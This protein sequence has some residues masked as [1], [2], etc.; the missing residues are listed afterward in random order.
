METEYMRK[1]AFV[2]GSSKGIGKG[3]A[4]EFAKAG[5]DIALNHRDSEKE[6]REAAQSVESLGARAVV[7]QGDVS[8]PA[9]INRM[10]DAFS[11]AYD[12]LDVMVNNAGITRFQ[13]F[14]EADADVLD[15]VVNTNFRGSFL[16]AQRAARIMVEKEIP[17]LIVNITSN[18]QK[19]CWPIASV[20][21]AS[22]AAVNKFTENIAMELAPYGIRAV[23]IAPGY[24][25]TRERPPEIPRERWDGYMQTIQR[26]PLGRMCET[27]EVGRACVFLA[28]EGAQYITGACLYMDG[29]A[30]LPVV[31][32][33][34]YI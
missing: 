10:F 20:Y 19:G 16:C 9:D 6:A 25:K 29:G 13:P 22:K 5:Y 28:G 18:H 31:T 11:G 17:G 32:E 30:L 3:I 27:W 15:S 33:N 2:T 24:T 1:V 4:L 8:V 23:S 26:I 21:A 14:L 34:R 12:R 7:I